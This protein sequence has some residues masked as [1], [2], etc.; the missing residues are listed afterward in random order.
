MISLTRIGAFALDW[1]EGLRRDDRRQRLY[2]VD[3]ATQTLHW[4]DNAEPPLN[5]MTL[6]AMPAMP[7][8]QV[9]TDG[10]RRWPALTMGCMSSIPT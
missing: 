1:D 6:P 8:G 9:P 2:F 5:S 3:C 7:A 4:L 10:G